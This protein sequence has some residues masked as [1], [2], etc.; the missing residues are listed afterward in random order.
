MR[1]V[2][3]EKKGF[4]LKTLKGLEVRPTLEQVKESIFNMIAPEIDNAI[5]ADV[6]CGSGN[7]GLEALSRGAKKC[8]FVDLSRDALKVVKENLQTLD[9]LDRADIVRLKLP[10]GLANLKGL[11]TV[12]IL[13]ADPP[14]GTPLSSKLLDMIAKQNLVR[15]GCLLVVEH[16]GKT[17]ISF[18]QKTYTL[19]REKK[20]GQSEVLILRKK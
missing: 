16:S 17:K 20:F 12:T 19:L 3:G 6:F 2:A 5:V 9:L 13:L 14:Y 10:D 18:N 8:F 7:L 1:I 11:D 15:S 4:K